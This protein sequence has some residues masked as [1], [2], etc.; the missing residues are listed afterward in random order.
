MRH[1]LSPHFA[2]L[3]AEAPAVSAP[4]NR[5]PYTVQ[6]VANAEGS[7][8]DPAT[9]I[10]A[11]CSLLTMDLVAAGH[12][13][14][15][16]QGTLDSFVALGKGRKIKAY[17]RHSWG[18]R[19][20]DEI[21]YWQNFRV[22]GKNVRADFHALSSF[23][24]H[25]EES[26]DKLFELAATMPA[27]FGVSPCIRFAP[28]WLTKGG[29]E[30]PCARSFTYSEGAG[31]SI[32]YSP[33]APPDAVRAD[34][35]ARVT[36]FTSADFVDEPAAN[37]GLLRAAPVDVSAKGVPPVPSPQP[38]TQAKAMLSQLIAKFGSNPTRLASAVQLHAAQ[39]NLSI[40][41][42]EAKLAAQEQGEELIR[43]RKADTDAK[44]EL[45]TLRAFKTTAEA[46]EAK[47]S[48]AGFKPADG[49]TAVDA[50][51][52]EVAKLRGQVAELQNSSP[53]V[54]TGAPAGAGGAKST[55]EAAKLRAE[56][57]KITGNSPEE[58]AR[59]GEI[60]AKLRALRTG[61]K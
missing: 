10:I 54:N 18:D 52:A 19:T 26:Y 14:F 7:R 15:I 53:A 16:D 59:R 36:G 42:I 44:A 28:V 41:E 25:D 55:D 22:D 21:G 5:D 38:A 2:Q 43:L 34:P 1:R 50:A 61:G 9:G 47:L 37:D 57:A 40:E 45:G 48:S 60:T 29:K 39:A 12:A 27:E 3:S 49:K 6:L 11:G 13:F 46:E 56:L 4:R 35:S 23:R 33:P 30:I 24:K 17:L 8:V 32:S 31:A 58:S 20:G 51:L